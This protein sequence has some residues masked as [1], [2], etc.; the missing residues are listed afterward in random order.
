MK[1][2][3][4]KFLGQRKYRLQF[5]AKKYKP[6]QAALNKTFHGSARKSPQQEL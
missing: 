1:A 2:L 6:N 3:V 4:S 5:E